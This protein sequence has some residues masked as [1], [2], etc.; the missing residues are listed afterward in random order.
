MVLETEP[1]QFVAPPGLSFRV[2]TVIPGLAPPG[3]FFPPLRG[4]LNAVPVLVADSGFSPTCSRYS[5]YSVRKNPV[6]STAIS[7]QNL[8][9]TALILHFE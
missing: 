8:L 7:H 3:S 2:R 5:P 1:E 4:F 6:F 9:W